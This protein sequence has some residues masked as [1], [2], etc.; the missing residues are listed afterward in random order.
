[1]NIISYKFFSFYNTIKPFYLKL[2]GTKEK[3]SRYL[4]IRDIEGKIHN[5]Q[6]VG[7]TKSL[8]HIQ[9]IQD[10]EFQVYAYQPFRKSITIFIS[11]F[12]SK[13]LVLHGIKE[14]S[15]IS[16]KFFWNWLKMLSKST[17]VSEIHLSRIYMKHNN[18]HRYKYYWKQHTLRQ[19]ANCK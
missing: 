7:T 5:I 17:S 18:I 14:E 15:C 1:V 12:L 16:A 2:S 4:R 19:Q 9:R 6:V 13:E 10:I 8:R 11:S 3:T